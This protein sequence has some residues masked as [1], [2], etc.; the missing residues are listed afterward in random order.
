MRYF[1]LLKSVLLA[2]ERCQNRKIFWPRSARLILTYLFNV[3]PARHSLP[4]AMNLLA[5]TVERHSK[6]PPPAQPVL[7]KRG[8]IRSF[9]FHFFFHGNS[10]LRKF[11]PFLPPKKLFSAQK[12]FQ[13]R[14][15]LPPPT[16]LIIHGQLQGQMSPKKGTF[17]NFAYF[18][19]FAPFSES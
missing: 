17:C 19:I 4:P 2:S 3:G 16:S 15:Q 10:F 12:K 14:A 13:L 9:F 18:H 6:T 8:Y 11:A 5:S 1:K 7:I